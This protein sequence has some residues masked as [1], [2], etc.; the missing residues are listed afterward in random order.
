MELFRVQW[1]WKWIPFHAVGRL[2]TGEVN[3]FEVRPHP[4]LVAESER[5]IVA[6]LEVILELNVN[7]LVVGVVEGARGE[8]FTLI[9]V[10]DHHDGE[11]QILAV[12]DDEIRL[13]FNSENHLH[14]AA[15]KQRC[16]IGV[17]D[18]TVAEWH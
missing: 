4:A 11:R 9:H 15:H 1:K 6:H 12:K 14:L 7:L 16:Q 13:L 2:V 18:H 17:K 8:D 3:A 10:F 5:I